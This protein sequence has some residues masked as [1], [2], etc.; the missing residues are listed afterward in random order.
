MIDEEVTAFVYRCTH[1]TTQTEYA[2]RCIDKACLSLEL[3]NEVIVATRVQHPCIV[4]LVALYEDDDYVYLILPLMKGGDL[5]DRIVKCWSH[6][7]TERHAA[8]MMK[9]ILSA[10]D[11][12]HQE[13]MVCRD[14]RPESIMFPAENIMSTTVLVSCLPQISWVKTVCS[15]P[16]YLAPELLQPQ[17]PQKST[18]AAN[19][20]SAGVIAYVVLCGFAPFRHDQVPELVKLII[21]GDYSFPS[22]Y[23]DNISKQAKDFVSALLVR[24]PSRRAT[25]TQALNHPWIAGLPG[26]TQ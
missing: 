26:A 5:F 4:S 8:R 3:Q 2:L 24:E 16:D 11:Y 21:K 19:I 18:C 25:A 13:G 23:W 20:W 15:S 9:S 14:L 12:L 17:N 22:P 10:L 6:G 1:L 7:Y